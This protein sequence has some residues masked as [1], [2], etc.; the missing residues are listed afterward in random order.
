MSLGKEDIINYVFFDKRWL[1]LASEFT[2]IFSAI[3]EKYQ[4][5]KPVKLSRSRVLTIFQKNP[6]RKTRYNLCYGPKII[7][8]NREKHFF[9]NNV[10]SD[11]IKNS[12]ETGKIIKDEIENFRVLNEYF[13]HVVE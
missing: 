9:K 7:L 6:F 10:K 1:W 2:T 5:L 12:C 4:I 13:V 11:R 8:V 3:K